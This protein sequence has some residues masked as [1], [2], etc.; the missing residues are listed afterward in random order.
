MSAKVQQILRQFIVS[1]DPQRQLL[2]DTFFN[3]TIYEQWAVAGRELDANDDTKVAWKEEHSCGEVYHWRGIYQRVRDLTRIINDGDIAE[4]SWRIGQYPVRNYCNITN[5]RLFNH[6]RVGT[7]TLIEEF[8]RVNV[9]AIQNVGF[10]NL[11]RKLH[12]EHEMIV[13]FPCAT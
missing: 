10:I 6:L 1:T 12:M 13:L 7:K 3:A 4:L 9:K 11:P 8:V 5:S 2:Q